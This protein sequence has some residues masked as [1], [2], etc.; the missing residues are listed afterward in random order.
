MRRIEGLRNAHPLKVSSVPLVLRLRLSQMLIQHSQQS[1]CQQGNAKTHCFHLASTYM[2][3]GHFRRRL[4]SAGRNVI[5]WWYIVFFFCQQFGFF[6]ATFSNQCCSLTLVMLR[7][8]RYWN[9]W[10]CQKYVCVHQPFLMPQRVLM[11][12]LTPA[13]CSC[14]LI[15]SNSVFFWRIS[16]Q[17][18]QVVI[19]LALEK[20][21]L[22]ASACRL[23]RLE[24][25][26][27]WINSALIYTETRFWLLI[28]NCVSIWEMAGLVVETSVSWMSDGAPDWLPFWINI[29]PEIVLSLFWFSVHAA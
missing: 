13:K 24:K 20:K 27:S 3:T 21:T 7:R 9:D 5:S 2:L 26:I 29:L 12:L 16:F 25:K 4:A 18:N 22:P 6:A 23:L 28:L 14:C 1:Q 15:S 11:S 10:V 19:S 17:R 8:Q